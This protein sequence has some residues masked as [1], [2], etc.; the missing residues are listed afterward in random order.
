M[1]EQV[2]EDQRLVAYEASVNGPLN[3]GS[4]P[5]VR[6]HDVRRLSGSPMIDLS[7]DHSLTVMNG[8]LHENP[9]YTPAEQLL[10]G[11]QRRTTN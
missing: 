11:L 4:T 8:V 6:V 3:R 5:T 10:D 2:L 7:P 1:V 9:F